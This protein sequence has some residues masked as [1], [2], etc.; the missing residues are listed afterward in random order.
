MEELEEPLFIFQNFKLS[1]DKQPLG[2]VW[3][4]ISLLAISQRNDKGA[5]FNESVFSQGNAV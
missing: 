2:K 4:K 1:Q 5:Y 3:N